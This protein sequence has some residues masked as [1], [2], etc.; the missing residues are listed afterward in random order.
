MAK[1]EAEMEVTCVALTVKE[2]YYNKIIRLSNKWFTFQLVLLLCAYFWSRS[3]FFIHNLIL[4]FHKL[5]MV[6]L[7]YC[8]VSILPSSNYQ[9]H[10]TTSN[11]LED[12]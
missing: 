5:S 11:A 1:S 7:I 9:P 3:H 6:L 2:T 12:S 8:M 4:R 10:Q